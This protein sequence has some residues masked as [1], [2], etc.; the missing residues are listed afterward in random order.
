MR[1]RGGGEERNDVGE[2]DIAERRE[3]RAEGLGEKN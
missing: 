2:R 3:R 1:E